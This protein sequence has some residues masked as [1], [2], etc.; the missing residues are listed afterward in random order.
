MF[1]ALK[2]NFFYYFY[3]PADTYNELT[4]PYIYLNLIFSKSLSIRHLNKKKNSHV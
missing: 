1:V 4:F 2:I 3:Y